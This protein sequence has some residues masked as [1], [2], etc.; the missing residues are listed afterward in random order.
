[1]NWSDEMYYKCYGAYFP[2]VKAMVYDLKK[3]VV[4]ERKQAKD[5]DDPNEE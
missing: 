4:T 5:E 2:G 1:M 3:A